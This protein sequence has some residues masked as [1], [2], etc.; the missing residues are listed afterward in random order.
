M[1]PLFP[2]KELSE[3][4]THIRLALDVS[5]KNSPFARCAR[6]F[7]LLFECVD[8]EVMSQSCY[9]EII[10]A[11]LVVYTA[12]GNAKQVASSSS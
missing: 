5:R 4:Y 3:F 7:S 9:T 11:Y 2:K 10:F 12:H 8:A 1:T 6:T